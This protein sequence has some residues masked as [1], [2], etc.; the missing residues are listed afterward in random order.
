MRCLGR[1]GC[2]EP[3]PFFLVLVITSLCKLFP[4]PQPSTKSP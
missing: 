1:Q 2:G 4:L 3:G